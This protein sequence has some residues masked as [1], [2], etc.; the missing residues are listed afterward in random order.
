LAGAGT[1]L[2][3]PGWYRALTAS[4]LPERLRRAYGLSL[5]PREQRSVERALH[6]IRRGYPF[7]PP[8]LRTVG[9]YQEALARLSGRKS[10]TVLTRLLNQLWIGSGAISG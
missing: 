6:W 3:S 2:S 10:P 1:W 4:L 8:R 9:P 5:G 7:L